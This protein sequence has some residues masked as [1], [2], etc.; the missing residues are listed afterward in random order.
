MQNLAAHVFL[1][2]AQCAIVDDVVKTLA[3]EYDKTHKP[4]KY[5]AYAFVDRTIKVQFKD[6]V[7]V[8]CTHHGRDLGNCSLTRTHATDRMYEVD[9]QDQLRRLRR[10][11][12][13]FVLH[14]SPPNGGLGGFISNA[15]DADGKKIAELTD[16]MGW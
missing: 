1:T 11:V 13:D 14:V 5:T 7:P 2:A 8:A 4:G 10:D 12:R 9:L 6:G 15:Y 16:Y 3:N